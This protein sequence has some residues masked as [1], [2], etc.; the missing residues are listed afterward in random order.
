MSDFP[1][2][3]RTLG[4]T[5]PAVG[6]LGLGCMGMSW[7]YDSAGRDDAQAVEVIRR[8]LEIGVTL[9]DTSDMYGPFTNEELVGRALEGRRD[10]AFLA[11]KGGLVV[12][13]P[14]TKAIHRDGRPEHMR[15]ALDGSLRRLGTD[16]V[17]LYQLHRADPD[18]PIEETWGAMAE[19]VAAGKARAIGL[20]E[21]AVDELERA[22]AIHPV[23]TVQSELSLWTREALDEVLPWCERNGAAFIP[24]SPLGRGYFTG[25]GRG[26]AR[27]TPTT[28]ARS[29]PASPTRRW[30][31]TRRSSSRS[32]AWP[33]ATTRRRG[34]SRS[35]GC[36]RR[37]STW[38]RSR[39]PGGSPTSRRTPRPP[40][41]SLGADDLAELDALPGPGGRALPGRVHALARGLR[42]MPLGGHVSRR[43]SCRSCWR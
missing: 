18:V 34:R 3:T 41:S 29:S 20:S 39:A 15:E 26:P 23:A 25:H 33:G 4:P 42:S 27:S 40:C 22:H 38:S 1:I 31:P 21:P 28:C 32:S 2:P 43:L 9:L 30:P 16:H 10:D 17:D 12:D 7:G 5:G 6:A 19:G 14:E 35:P 37:A 11:T 24:F 13:D 36:W 8:A